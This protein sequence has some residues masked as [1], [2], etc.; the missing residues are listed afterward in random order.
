MGHSGGRRRGVSA[1]DGAASARFERLFGDHHLLVARYAQRRVTD[2]AVADVVAEVF[3]I[4]WRRLGDI[5]TPELPWLYEV[6]H[7]VIANSTRRRRREAEFV[8][9][10]GGSLIARPGDDTALLATSR[11]AAAAAFGQLGDG[12]REMLALVAWEGLDLAD[13]AATLGVSPG[14]AAVRLHRARN[15]L[16]AALAG[17]CDLHAMSLE[18]AHD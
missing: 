4:A 9:D 15:R 1:V 13:L 11:L 5:G 17:T 14:T 18:A 6:A 10:H 3:T 7:H 2:D 8:R 16:Q 12:D